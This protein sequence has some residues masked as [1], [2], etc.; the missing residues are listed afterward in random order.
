[1]QHVAVQRP[2]RISTGVPGE[3]N[4]SNA[5]SAARLAKSPRLFRWAERP[6]KRDV[7]DKLV[8]S[9]HGVAGSDHQMMCVAKIVNSTAIDDRV[10]IAA[11]LFWSFMKDLGAE[12]EMIWKLPL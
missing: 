2:P 7:G 10:G 12:S 11:N 3:T 6:L 4:H 5:F 9:L 1:M 8:R